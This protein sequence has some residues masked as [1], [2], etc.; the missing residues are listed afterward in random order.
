MVL[1]DSWY[2]LCLLSRKY[3]NKCFFINKTIRKCRSQTKQK[4]LKAQS[5]EISTECEKHSL[6]VQQLAVSQVGCAIE[7]VNHLDFT[8]FSFLASKNFLT[9]SAVL[10]SHGSK[11]QSS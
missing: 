2:K 5:P 11:N 9:S 6:V 8:F 1:K 7:I 3:E 10:N 4:Q